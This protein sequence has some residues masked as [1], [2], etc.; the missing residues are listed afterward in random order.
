MHITV[1]NLT[2][3]FFTAAWEKF[4]IHGDITFNR[5]VTSVTYDELGKH[6]KVLCRNLKSNV[7]LPVETFD[8]V[9]CASGH[10]TFPNIPVYEGSQ[11]FEGRFMHSREFR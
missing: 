2:C 9:I 1:K 4:N 10:F 11:L 3:Y 7:I 6:F 8:Y 5:V